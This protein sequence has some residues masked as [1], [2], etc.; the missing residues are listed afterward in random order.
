VQ[1]LASGPATIPDIVEH[2]YVDVSPALHG[3][4]AQ[5]VLAHLI[6]LEDSGEVESDGSRYRLAW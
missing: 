3:A 1:R 2:V 6:E 4:A 5:S